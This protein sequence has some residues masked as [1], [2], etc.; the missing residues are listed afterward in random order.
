MNYNLAKLQEQFQTVKNDFFDCKSKLL[1]AARILG[2]SPDN[3]EKIVSLTELESLLSTVKKA[4]E[5]RSRATEVRQ[6]ALTVLDRVLTVFHRDNS[7]FKPLLECKE[8]AKKMRGQISQ[9]VEVKAEPESEALAKGN[10][11]FSQVL[12]LIEGA[13]E[14]DDDRLTELQD[15]V[16]Q[17]FKRSLATAALRGKLTFGTTPAPAVPT[18]APV[19]ENGAAKSEVE[20]IAPPPVVPPVAPPVSAESIEETEDES[21]PWELPAQEEEAAEPPVLEP[22]VLEPPVA[23]PPVAPPVI[24]HSHERKQEVA[25]VPVLEPP[26]VEPPVVSQTRE[27]GVVSEHELVG[28]NGNNR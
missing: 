11:A 19:I 26:V 2:V 1:E 24:K 13:E 18:T 20:D 15:A 17:H 25:E 10:H 8:K 9:S 5:E 3:S 16:A 7:H 23:P 28:L 22:P 4:E 6:Q 27:N 14:L 12:M 21:P